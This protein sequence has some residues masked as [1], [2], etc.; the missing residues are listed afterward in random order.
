MAEP[1]WGWACFCRLGSSPGPCKAERHGQMAT[2]DSQHLLVSAV[3]KTTANRF[4]EPP[5]QTRPWPLLDTRPELLAVPGIFQGNA[6]N[7]RS[8]MG[9]VFNPGIPDFPEELQ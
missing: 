2:S 5:G 1:Y 3:S 8:S 7:L 4:S 9:R 6:N